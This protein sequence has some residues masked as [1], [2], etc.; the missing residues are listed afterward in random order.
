MKRGRLFYRYEI[1]GEGGFKVV[2]RLYAQKI[3]LFDVEF[4]QNK[5]NLSIDACDCKKLFAISRN[6]CYN[7]S[8][9]KYYGKLS[10]VKFLQNK[11]G[12]ALCFILFLVFSTVFDGYVSKIEYTADGEYFSPVIERVLQSKGIRQ[13]TLLKADLKDLE[14]EVYLADE[15]ISFVSI[16]K[17]GRILRIEARLGV[18]K[19]QPIDVKKQR[20]LSTVDGE[21][22]GIN[23]LGGTAKVKVGDKVT[24][25]SL[26]ID[27][28]YEDGGDV[29]E[30]YALGEVEIKTEFKFEYKCSTCGKKY[31]NLAVLLAKQSL[32]KEEIVGEKIEQKKDGNQTV[33]T[34]T[35]YYLVIVG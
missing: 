28:Y 24:K 35:L 23:L 32:G 22:V 20:I 7:I 30:T 2:E 34:V 21:V 26:L 11:I 27:G 13:N 25:G 4:A 3:A 33:Y 31:E 18:Q 14:R 17:R 1:L 9:V 5:I 12:L 10:P 15:R 19:T 29:I 16:E 8:K 6:M